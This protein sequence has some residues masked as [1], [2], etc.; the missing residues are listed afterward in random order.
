MALVEPAQS[1]HATL[2]I[3][4]PLTPPTRIGDAFQHQTELAIMPQDVRE[5]LADVV[6]R[7]HP[8]RVQSISW[9]LLEGRI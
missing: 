8:A 5:H 3:V 2:A 1:I 9:P 4:R 7:N 6:A